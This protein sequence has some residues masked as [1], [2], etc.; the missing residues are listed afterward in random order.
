MAKKDKKNKRDAAAVQAHAKPNEKTIEEVRIPVVEEHATVSKIVRE[1]RT[2]SVR[3]S[4]VTENRAIEDTLAHHSVEIRR[5]PMDQVVDD[6]PETREEGDVTI[7]P[8]IE[9]RLV[10]R[11]E[12]V[13]VEEIHLHRQRTEETVSRSVPLTRTEVTIEES[14]SE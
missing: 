4:P 14:D 5:V 7:V 9:E 2:I 10:V 8:V 6:V 11:K 13:L 12:L 3:T 1:G